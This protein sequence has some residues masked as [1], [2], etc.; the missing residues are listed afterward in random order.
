MRKEMASSRI[1]DWIKESILSRD[2]RLPCSESEMR[3]KGEGEQN[4]NMRM[5]KA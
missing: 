5:I 4:E 2:S 1:L 3:T